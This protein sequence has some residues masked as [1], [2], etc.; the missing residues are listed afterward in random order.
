MK[1]WVNGVEAEIPEK[2]VSYEDVSRIAWGKV[3]EGL[4]VTWSVRGKNLNGSLLP[5]QSVCSEPGMI[6]N[7]VRTGSA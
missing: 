5:G 1:C 6:F 3:V 7:A 2:P 4:T